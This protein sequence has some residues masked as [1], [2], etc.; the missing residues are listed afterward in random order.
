MYKYRKNF[1]KNFTLYLEISLLFTSSVTHE[2][3]E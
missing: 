1:T 3:F 2:Q